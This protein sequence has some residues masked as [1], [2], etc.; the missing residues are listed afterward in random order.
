MQVWSSR[1][2]LPLTVKR[3]R[4]DSRCR[5]LEICISPDSIKILI[6]W[7]V[8][9]S[10]V[11]AFHSAFYSFPPPLG[12]HHLVGS[13]ILST[14]SGWFHRS[15]W[16]RTGMVP[17]LL[18]LSHLVRYPGYWLLLGKPDAYHAESNPVR[19][20]ILSPSGRGLM[21]LCTGTWPH[22]LANHADQKSE[23]PPG[24]K[25]HGNRAIASDWAV[26]VWEHTDSWLKAPI[27][28]SPRTKYN[29]SKNV[30]AVTSIARILA[31]LGTELFQL[32]TQ[33]QIGSPSTLLPIP[34]KSKSNAI[35]D[36]C[37]C[38]LCHDVCGVCGVDQ[39]VG[40]CEDKWCF[41]FKS[42]LYIIHLLLLV[43]RFEY[44]KFEL[45]VGDLLVVLRL[46]LDSCDTWLIFPSHHHRGPESVA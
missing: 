9:P 36:K 34:T 23:G 17:A 40:Y 14:A 1:L 11:E 42:S 25:L 44:S 13:F 22:Y 31:H 35:F 30:F 2:V 21:R 27:G 29:R 39:Q 45:L 46:S 28:A 4:F 5:N 7:A 8:T 10:I 20:D 19:K 37:M 38:H 18:A 12:G 26:G 43:L 41:R 15:G 6:H 33:S 24:K 32:P 16:S 3:T